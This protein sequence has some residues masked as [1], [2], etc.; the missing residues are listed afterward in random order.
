M[1]RTAGV[2]TPLSQRV[3]ERAAL[4]MSRPPERPATDANTATGTTPT[5]PTNAATAPT[6]TRA[7]A[8][9]GPRTT[10]PGH[11]RRSFLARGAV[12]GSAL[13]VAPA[14]YLLRP[15]TAYAAVTDVCG[16]DATCLPG[17]FT[18]FC[19]TINNGVNKCPPGS[20]PGGWWRAGTGSSWCC[21]ADRYYVDCQAACPPGC[22][23]DS[24]NFCPGCQ[25]CTGGCY[26]GPSC[27]QRNVCQVRFRYGQ[28]NQQ[29]GCTGNVLCRMVTCTPPWQIAGLNCASGPDK[30]DTRTAEHSAPCLQQASWSG[31][32]FPITADFVQA[33]PAVAQ[34]PGSARVDLFARGGDQQ[35][36]WTTNAFGGW[37]AMRSLGA[38]PVGCIGSPSAVSWGPGN[39]NLFVWGGD[40][41]LWQRFS[42]DGGQSWAGWFKPV[43]D[44]GTLASVPAVCSWGPGRVD[45]FVIGTNGFVYHRWYDNGWNTSGW[46]Y[47][48]APPATLQYSALTATAWAPG[49]VDVFATAGNSLWQSFYAG[50]WSGWIQPD[51][52]STTPLVSAPSSA[53]WGPGHL[54][55]FGRG[56][57]GG[58]HWTNWYRNYWS[59]WQRVGIPSDVFTGNPA[60]GAA[61]CQQL[62]VFARG[63]AGH[64][65]EY[66]Y[67]G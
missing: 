52:S 27:D 14:R 67:S 38:P 31:G 66:V 11:T 51:N 55:V 34:A 4:R 13:A 40:N 18:V 48:G 25:S 20:I 65:R 9:T 54:A 6:T 57:D 30:T 58:L 44:D 46:E 32:A 17:G 7:R 1:M 2:R 29:I 60:A 8:G 61:G 26:S 53:S 12:V 47:R 22:P 28:C 42:S 39:L 50:G 63:N 56:T 36:H 64:I 41:R 49:R 16:P 45:V 10:R 3:V 37:S 33:S 5:T 62:N 21:G 59:G 43:G 15:G 23:C 24:G 19:C 35:I